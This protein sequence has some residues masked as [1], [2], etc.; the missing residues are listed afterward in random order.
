LLASVGVILNNVRRQ[1]CNTVATEN[2]SIYPSSFVDRPFNNPTETYRYYSFPFCQVHHDGE[3]EDRKL[4]QREGANPHNQRLGE[5]IVGDRRE[6][7]PYDLT[8]ND[9]VDW[10]LLCKQT[11]SPADLDKLK[12]AI[13]EYYFFEMFVED[14]PMWGYIGDFS[15]EDFIIGEIPGS[16]TFLFTHLHFTIGYNNEFQIVSAKVNADVSTMRTGN[17]FFFLPPNTGRAIVVWI[18]RKRKTGWMSNSR[19]RWNGSKRILSGRIATQ[20]T[21]RARFL[22][23]SKFIGFLLSIRLFWFCF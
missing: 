21:R 17:S 1:A 5:S 10:R 22:R 4:D 8:F 15:D 19:T 6:T 2:S 7:S 11:L 13:H 20:N 3:D 12:N 23:L 16:R 9:L 18:L 14:L